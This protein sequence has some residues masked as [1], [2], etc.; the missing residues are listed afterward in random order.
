MVKNKSNSLQ[1]NTDKF[2]QYN[3]VVAS[4]QLG[5]VQ[6]L[7]VHFDVQPNYFDDQQK[8]EL[9]YDLD[10]NHLEYDKSGNVAVAFVQC[11]VTAK[12]DEV[13]VLTC[14]A[15]YSIVYSLAEE[16]EEEAVLAFV[17]RVC[18]FACYPYFR[19]L[20]STFDWAANTRLPILPV[21]KE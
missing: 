7:S 5:L 18:K 20:F 4:A 13:E 8:N 1:K 21:L 16:F 2:E 3:K 17:K 14:E 19:S 11:N 12:Q 9:S 6:L 10:I 15:A